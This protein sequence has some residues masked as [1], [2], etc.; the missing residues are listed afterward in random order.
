MPAHSTRLDQEGVVIPPTR[1]ARGWELDDGAARRRLSSGMRGPRQREA[2]LRAQL[3]ANRL[4]ARR[5]E[6]LADRHGDGRCSQARW[7]RCSTT[8]SAARGARSR[9]SPTGRYRAAD[10][11][12]DDGARTRRT[13]CSIACEV[14]VAGDELEV[15]FAGTDAPERR[16]PQLP[17]VGDEVRRRT[18]WCGC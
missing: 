8:P 12:E 13:T 6:Q 2:D 1:L 11:L 17:A 5:L 18:T 7:R 9:R 4:A 16:Q 15:D 10:V 3:A 14:R